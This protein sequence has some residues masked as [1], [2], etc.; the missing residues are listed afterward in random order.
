[1]ACSTR[2]TVRCWS[3]RRRSEALF[4]V[5]SLRRAVTRAGPRAL[6]ANEGDPVGPLGAGVV[7][8]DQAGG[9]FPAGAL[10]A[11]GAVAAAKAA[12][13]RPGHG[14]CRAAA[15]PRARDLKRA[16]AGGL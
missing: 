5:A 14:V 15:R 8:A 4:E 7:D 12:L 11:L 6:T 16:V 13:G 10:K 2:L 3:S 1:M 9:H